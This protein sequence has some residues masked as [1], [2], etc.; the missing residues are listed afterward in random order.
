MD[1]SLDTGNIPPR[2]REDV[3]GK[4]GLWD[5]LERNEPISKEKQLYRP[6]AVYVCAISTTDITCRNAVSSIPLFFLQR[7]EMQ[8]VRVHCSGQ[9]LCSLIGFQSF[10]VSV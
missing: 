9:G 8:E 3:H 6:A 7:C 10:K 5:I 1:A 2:A 4:H